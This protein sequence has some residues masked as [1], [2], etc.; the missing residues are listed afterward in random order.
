[1]SPR[2]RGEVNMKIWI[3]VL[4]A[5]ACI[6]GSAFCEDITIS[7][8]AVTADGVGKEIGTITATDT[9]YGLLLKP[10]L[11]ELPPGLHGFHLH[12]NPS[13]DPAKKDDKVVAAQSA[14]GHFDPAKTAKHEGPYGE[15]H[16]GDIPPLFVDADG[17]ANVPV[18]APRLKTS[19]L[20]GH[21]VMI[22]AGSDN[23]ADQPQPLGGGGARIACGVI[24]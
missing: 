6:A 16:L 12:E 21:A 20:K 15:G 22:H 19:D 4:I 10:Q 23:Y 5:T 11:G 2:N 24:K 3:V 13:C 7:I 17:K 14:G 1:M 9:K 18:L 8:N